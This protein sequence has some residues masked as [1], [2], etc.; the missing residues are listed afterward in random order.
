MHTVAHQLFNVEKEHNVY[1][2]ERTN[3]RTKKKY[4]YNFMASSSVNLNRNAFVVDAVVVVA[5]SVVV[6]IVVFVI[7]FVWNMNYEQ[8]PYYSAADTNYLYVKYMLLK[9]PK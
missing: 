5:A 6:V 3:E 7:V 2:T 9:L 4:D 8:Y 1:Q